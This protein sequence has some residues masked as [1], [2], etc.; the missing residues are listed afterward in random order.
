MPAASFGTLPPMAAPRGGGAGG[1]AGTV[2]PSRPLAA[3]AGLIVLAALLL[4]GPGP[5][6]ASG[7]QFG[8]RITSY[9]V[10]L[11]IE[12]N[13][14]L[15]VTETIAYDFASNQKH[16]ILRD[17]P[18][19]L[20]YDDRYDRIYPLRVE[21]V[22]ASAGTPA[23]YKVESVG[24]DKRIRIGDADRTI[25][26]QH[27]YTIVYRVQQALNGFEEHD[28][29]FWNAIG[30]H[31]AVFI[32]SARVT[33]EAPATIQKVLCFTGPDQSRLPCD[34]SGSDGATARFTR[35]NMG[36]FENV[37]VVVAIPKGA[38]PNPQPKLDE[39]WSV[40]RAFSLTPATVASA[41]GLLAA[42]VAAFAYVGWRVGRDRR[43]AGSGVD[44]VFGGPGAEEQAVPLMERPVTPVEFVPPDGLRAGQVGTLVD[45]RA[46]PLDVIATVVDLAVR[47]FLRIDEIPKQGWFG[48]AD[49]TLVKLKDADDDLK[50]YERLLLNGL[51]EAGDE[52]KLS[53]LKNT[54]A[55]RLRSVQDSLY[56]DAVRQKW[57]ARRPDK[58]RTRWVAIGM[59]ATLVGLGLTVLAAIYTHAGLVPIPLFI[60]G[61]LLL[62][63][64]GD[65][66]RRTAQGTATLRR[67]MGFRRFMEESEKERARFAERQNLFSEY[68]PFAIVFGCTEKWARAFE[69][70][71]G[72]LPQTGWYSGAHG[73]TASSFS[74]SMDGF[75]TTTAGTITSTPSGSGGSGFGGGGSS[76]GGGGGG[77]GGSW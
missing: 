20:H 7:A 28:E 43:Y 18:V 69:G 27:T 26:G 61:L 32:E 12:E 47:G 31:W 17:I 59:A 2:A 6:A 65:M 72:Q 52:V 53:S 68:L 67:V 33:V 74:S 54:F 64:S 13:G 16:G 57:F 37:T 14:D 39:R 76:G 29:L 71:D 42:V 48:K 22:S 49:W 77:G 9:D 46:H 21:S 45:E 63:A 1:W 55:T 75:T 34:E 38:V 36:P 41:G 19:R 30:S 8:E 56:A 40:G 70:I 58:V 24:A 51:F 11:R 44:V 5:A 3:L 10:I 73:F 4:A 66:P 25:S 35:N 62:A 23:E 50:A 15:L 60:G